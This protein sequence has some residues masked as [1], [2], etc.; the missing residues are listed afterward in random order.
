MGA[1]SADILTVNSEFSKRSVAKHLHV[2]TEAI[3]LTPMAVDQRY[4][5]PYAKQ[6]AREKFRSL[7]GF[8]RFVLCVSRIEPR[9]N[10]AMLLRI[11]L[12][13]QLYKKGYSPRIDR[14]PE[15]TITR[16]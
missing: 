2:K 7:Y 16:F 8:D 5:E 3:H 14:A 15:H 13:L 9:K 10:H 11:Y 12:E 6:E 4:F 1:R